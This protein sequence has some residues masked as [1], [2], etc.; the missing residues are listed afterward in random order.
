MVDSFEE[1]ISLL[2]LFLFPC[3]LCFY[4]TLTFVKGYDLDL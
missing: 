3:D 4:S 2:D 1:L